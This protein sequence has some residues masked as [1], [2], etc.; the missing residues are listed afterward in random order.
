[1]L[2]LVWHGPTVPVPA[3]RYHPPSLRPSGEEELH[4]SGAKV[5]PVLLSQCP[6]ALFCLPKS[7]PG[8]A[9]AVAHLVPSQLGKQEPLSITN[10]KKLGR[11]WTCTPGR[12]QG[13]RRSQ[14]KSQ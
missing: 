10:I 12:I 14:Q 11:K 8:L 4:V 13:L 3:N 6:V 2:P 7:S 9:C 5:G 1:M